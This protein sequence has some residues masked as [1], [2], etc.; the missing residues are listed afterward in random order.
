MPQLIA[1]YLF[2][3][4]LVSPVV[5][6]SMARLHAMSGMDVLLLDDLGVMRL[7]IPRHPSISFVHLLQSY[8]ETD[9]LFR[10]TRQ[11]ALAKKKDLHQIGVHE[12]VCEITAETQTAGY[13]LLSGYRCDPADNDFQSTRELWRRL[14]RSGLP[15]RWTDWYRAWSRLPSLTAEQ[16][17]A[18]YATVSL[19]IRHV[20][21]GMK[22]AEE[23]LD[24]VLPPLVQE[25]QQRIQDEYAK[26]LRMQQVA[27]DLG[28]C[29]EHLS[30]SFHATTGMRFGEFLA[31]TRI[32]AACDALAETDDPISQI[33][34]K[35]G[36][37][38][39]SRFNRCF[40]K[41]RET[42]PRSWRKR[43]RVQ[44]RSVA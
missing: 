10:E 42:T 22:K 2:S 34:H 24:A 23:P 19:Y 37:S 27:A 3:K 25:A 20:L 8:P 7:S 11:A 40:R 16:Q 41:H 33:A 4:L 35:C 31:E 9:R 1:K 29:P 14:V 12:V 6:E 44:R 30:R 36:F 21:Q 32:S 39:L 5:R 43:A 28:V 17:S 38:T 18:W 26:P 15:I 13:L